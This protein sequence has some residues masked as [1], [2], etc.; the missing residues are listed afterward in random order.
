MKVYTYDYP[1]A[2]IVETEAEAVGYPHRTARGV[3]QH[4]N[5]HFATWA[6]AHEALL[7]N[8]R[9][10]LNL[11]ALEAKR[12][13]ADVAKSDQLVTSIAIRLMDAERLTEGA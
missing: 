12:L 2:T 7:A 11:Q 4:D 10:G 8:L 5:T 9:A 1:T 6:E 3:L 13:R